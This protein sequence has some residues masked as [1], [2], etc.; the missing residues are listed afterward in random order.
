[1]KELVLAE[2]AGFCFGVQRSVEMAEQLLESGVKTASLGELIHNAQVVG[3]M[4]S[5]GLRVIQQPSEALPGETVLIRAH[6]VSEAVLHELRDND[7]T[8]VKRRILLKNIYKQLL[9]YDR[10]DTDTGLFILTERR[11]IFK[12]DK[13][14]CLIP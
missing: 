5:R 13:S 4:A 6:G 8:V 9:G 3:D 2:S 10:I 12:H 7:R 14:A 11:L 1:M